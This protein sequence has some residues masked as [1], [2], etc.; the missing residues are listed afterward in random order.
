MIGA[1]ALVVAP[2]IV[3][4]VVALGPDR[5]GS[6]SSP[7]TPAYETL[8]LPGLEH[9][10]EF[11]LPEPSTGADEPLAVRLSADGSTPRH[12]WSLGLSFDAREI[13]NPMRGTEDSNLALTLAE[14]DRPALRFGGNGIDR[15]VWWTS[16][17]EPAPDWASVTVNPADLERVA[18]VAE[19]VDATVTIELDLG[20]D[21]PAR[22]ADMA[23][24]AR[25]AFGERLLAVSIGN[26]PNGFHHEGSPNWR[27][28]T[29]TGRP[30]RTRNL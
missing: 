6:P 1:G 19:E 20:H 4:G 10:D 12:D 9:P 3:L 14:L 17:E 26:E 27:C 24:H 30:R 8:F 23:A 7:D 11:V 13:A 29:S 28:G 22:A 16:S 25:E 15:H 18:A 2:A 5:D 21:D